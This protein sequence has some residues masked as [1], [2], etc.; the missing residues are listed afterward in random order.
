MA[1]LLIIANP[2]AGRG[3]GEKRI[4]EARR[5][6]AAE[7][8]DCEVHVTEGP[9]DAM[10]KAELE[11]AHYETIVALGG[12]GSIQETAGGLARARLD[13]PF[14]HDG[15][16]ARLG[17]LPA[18]TGND[19]IKAVGLP[20]RF[21]EAFAV[22]L[23]GRSR[24]LDLG[25]VRWRAAGEEI[26]RER[27]FANNVGLGFEGQVGWEADRLR[28]PLRGKPL[29]LLALMRVLK[30]LVN[31]PLNIRFSDGEVLDGPKLLV[32]A[33]NGTTSGGGF[34]LNPQ[35]DPFDGLLDFCVI[36]ARGRREIL[37]FLPKAMKGKHIGLKGVLSRRDTCVELASERPFHGHADGELLGDGII[38]A[39]IEI[40][41]NLLPL[42]C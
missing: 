32:S 4:A 41:P 2:A 9:G 28:L 19:L 37:R 20:A 33:G 40:L 17:I 13:A 7:N 6:L 3:M 21:E 5:L 42:I 31:P 29:Y 15:P 38:W 25:R 8:L 10:Q 30:D 26:V 23:R 36:D 1:A 22:L 11:A 18:G 16:F 27:I 14:D 39:H 35:A 34:K 12:D 24:D